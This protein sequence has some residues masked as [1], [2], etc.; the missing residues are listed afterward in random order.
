VWLP[1]IK[2][3]Q[4]IKLKVSASAFAAYLTSNKISLQVFFKNSGWKTQPVLPQVA[5]KGASY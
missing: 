2:A 4:R 5:A 3:S 1:A